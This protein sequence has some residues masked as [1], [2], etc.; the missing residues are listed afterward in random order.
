MARELPG[1][2]LEMPMS[3]PV[4]PRIWALKVRVLLERC[5]RGRVREGAVYH[6]DMQE[7]KDVVN[8]ARFDV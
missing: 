2:L 5:R 1:L 8:G 3:G 6:V 4:E 7:N